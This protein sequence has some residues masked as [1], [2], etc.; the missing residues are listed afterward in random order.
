MSVL[1]ILFFIIFVLILLL[2]AI[3]AMYAVHQWPV[4]TKRRGPNLI[5]IGIFIKVLTALE[6]IPQVVVA[7]H[8]NAVQLANY[9]LISN[10]VVAGINYLALLTMAIGLLLLGKQLAAAEK[11]CRD[12]VTATNTIDSQL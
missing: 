5:A 8:F 4:F 11:Q 6:F 12:Q 1:A 7:R 3:M 2:P 10:Y 9:S